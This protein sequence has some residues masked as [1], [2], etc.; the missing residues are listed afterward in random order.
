MTIAE[1]ALLI[2]ASGGQSQSSDTPATWYFIVALVAVVMGLVALIF[3]QT[4]ARRSPKK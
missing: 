2:Q 4:S 1:C 3:I